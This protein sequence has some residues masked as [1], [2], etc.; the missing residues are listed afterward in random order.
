MRYPISETFYLESRP[1]NHFYDHELESLL[2]PQPYRGEKPL[3]SPLQF[4]TVQTIIVGDNK[5]SFAL[6]KD[7][8]AGTITL[9][10]ELVRE[11]KTYI[12]AMSA[13][14]VK[15]NVYAIDNLVF[16][17]RQEKLTSRH[18][19]TSVLAHIGRETLTTA[20]NMMIPYPH[21][22]KGTFGRFGR[23]INRS[24][25]DTPFFWPGV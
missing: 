4:G 2:C 9:E 23:F 17:N 18:E 19:I 6:K 5:F 14:R 13:H 24:L 22:E 25:P 10:A 8:T 3:A 1:P 7:K 12:T 11:G 20:C 16:D 15:D 21:E